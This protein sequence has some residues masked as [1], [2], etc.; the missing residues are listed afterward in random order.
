MDHKRLLRHCE[1]TYNLII[2]SNITKVDGTICKSEQEWFC[3][4]IFGYALP[5]QIDCFFP[6]N[7]TRNDDPIIHS[8]FSNFQIV[9]LL[10]YA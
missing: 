1:V 4:S 10:S 7:V 3:V 2:M 8:S 5:V 9:L 6:G